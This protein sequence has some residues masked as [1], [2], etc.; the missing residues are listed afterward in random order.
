DKLS[1]VLFLEWQHQADVQGTDVKNLRY[2]FQLPVK[3]TPS[4]AAIARA[5]EGRPV[6]KWPGVT[7]S[8]D[9]EEGKALLGTPNGNSLGWFLINHKA[10]LGLKTVE[11]VTVF[12]VG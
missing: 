12:G 1:D 5:L 8:M 6:S 9:S 7:L 4:Q 2:Y 10:Q 3:N 11:S